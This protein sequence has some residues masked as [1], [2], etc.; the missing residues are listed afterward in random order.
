MFSM[1]K[2]ITIGGLHLRFVQDKADT[3]GSATIFEMT[4]E[5][6]ARMPIAHHHESWDETVYGLDGVST[7]RVDGQDVQ[8][9][10]GES[11]FIKRGVVHGFRNDGGRSA[12]CLCVLTPGILG[13]DYFQEIADLLAKGA[14][15]A[16]MAAVMTKHGLIPS[17]GV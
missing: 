8:V 1:T 7:W 6:A 11:A 17:P 3:A 10:P 5:P 2:T 15:P 13:S 4:V 14:A 16:S 9:G 12:K